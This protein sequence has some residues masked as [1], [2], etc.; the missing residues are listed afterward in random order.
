MHISSEKQQVWCCWRISQAKDKDAFN[1]KGCFMLQGYV[2]LKGG[3]ASMRAAPTQE[4]DGVWFNCSSGRMDMQTNR[5]I[6]R[7]I[8]QFFYSIYR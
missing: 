1:L 5:Q 4:H 6:N 2:L 8:G 3:Q 7:S